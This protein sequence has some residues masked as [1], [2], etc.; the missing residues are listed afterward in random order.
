MQLKITLMVL[1]GMSGL[2]GWSLYDYYL[3][4]VAPPPPE[5][6]R[7]AGQI[8]LFNAVQVIEAERLEKGALPEDLTGLIL[9]RGNFEYV[10]A[11]TGYTLSLTMPDAQLRHR[12]GDDVQLLLRGAGVR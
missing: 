10:L 3:R 4:P 9:P 7:R 8:M 5:S 2:A 11:D 12:S 1:I 6:Q